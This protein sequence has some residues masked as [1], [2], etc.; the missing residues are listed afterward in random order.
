MTVRQALLVRYGAAAVV[1]TLV[2]VA[3]V[4]WVDNVRD[5]ETGAGIDDVL[6]RGLPA[7]APTNRFTDGT[8]RA[9][10][11]VRH[12][13]ATRSR[14]LPEDMGSGLAWGDCDGDGFDDLYVVNFVAPIG[15]SAEDRATR[16]GNALYRNRTDG[17]FEEIGEVAGVD[18]TAF[19]MG[20]SWGDY[21]GDGDVDLYVTNYGANVLFRNQGN[22]SFVDVTEEAGVGGGHHFSAGAVW[23]DYDGDDDLDLYVTNYVVFDEAMQARGDPMMQY[24]NIVPFTLNPASYQPAANWL[25]R[26][27]GDGRFTEVAESA[28]VANAAGRSLSAA[29]FDADADGDVDLYVAN[30]ISDNA[31]FLNRGDGSFEDISTASLTADYRGAMGL[32][33]ADYDRDADL[34]FFVTHWI[35]QENALYE[36]HMTPDTEGERPLFTDVA[37]LVGLG[38]TGLDRVGWGTS[39]IDF[40]N[41]G[42]KDLFVANGHT[43][44]DAADPTRLL[45][46]R[47]QLFWNRGEEGFFELSEVAG[48]PFGRLLVARGAAAADYDRDGDVDIA[49]LEHGGG[50]LLLVN[51]GAP[52]NHWVEIDLQQDGGNRRGIGALIR[53]DTG[54]QSQLVTV[55]G[56]SSYL[57]QDSR[58]AHFGLGEATS[59]DRVVVRWPDGTEEAFAGLAAD[60]RHTLL[61]GNG[62]EPGAVA[63]AGGA[64]SAATGGEEAAA[65]SEEAAAGSG[66]DFWAAYRAANQ[67]RRNDDRV[68]AI[69]AYERALAIRPE[70]L[71]T[72]HNLAQLRYGRGEVVEAQSLLERLADLDP[73]GN[74]AWQQLS[75]VSG[76][77]IAGWAPDLEH[78]DAMIDRALEVNPNNSESHLLKA[79]WAAYRGDLEAAEAEVEV[80]LGLSPRG[81]EAHT[82]AI[83]LAV[84]AGDDDRAERLRLRAIAAMCGSEATE[85]TAARAATEAAGPACLGDTLHAA[86]SAYWS[87][88]GRRRSGAG[89]HAAGDRAADAALLTAH[90]DLDGDGNPDLTALA[91]HPMQPA[92]LLVGGGS[93]AM[94]VAHATVAGVGWSNET[95]AAGPRPMPWRGVFLDDE[96]GR[97]L[98]LVGGGDA[99]V[100]MYEPTGAVWSERQVSG[101]PVQLA[102]AV[103]VAADWNG[104]G[105]TDLFFANVLR[106]AAP[107]RDGSGAGAK[108]ESGA[109]AGA[110]AAATVEPKTKS[111]AVGKIYWRRGADRFEPDALS[112]DGPLSAALAFDADGDGDPDLVTARALPV[113]ETAVNRLLQA[114][115]TKA[116]AEP[117]PLLTL[118][119]NDGGVLRR[120]ADAMPPIHATIQDLAVADVD[121]DVEGLLDLYVATGGLEPE[122]IEGDLLLTNHGDRFVD[123]SAA[124][125]GEARWG[126][127]LR[128]WP[129]TTGGFV[130]LRGGFGPADERLIVLSA[131]RVAGSR[132]R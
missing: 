130:L 6:A 117:P 93:A 29:W 74:R 22:C 5:V 129:R 40:D 106:S 46:Q 91:D 70:H 14:M 75:R 110:E 60:A 104:D 47:M 42:W 49:V 50:V 81:A 44:E 4:V 38:A 19:G 36:N 88:D 24:G 20:A 126:R 15:W 27:D 12:F 7:N 63:A 83:W 72:L 11:S 69:V 61:R 67:A 8:A 65:G 114:D 86:L 116:P 123:E 120:D 119:R 103:M 13:P 68:A 112:I 96:L 122:R 94:Q 77:P 3:A 82:L 1:L 131:P 108:A 66:E 109:E 25:F 53:V 118:W 127:T 33:I 16:P 34:D 32:A 107:D 52:D 43:L 54:E 55:G 39:F 111:D 79:R 101:L 125:F 121:G 80:A 9:G 84:G 10:I 100:R 23:A 97:V 51:S 56:S 128:V 62:D 92:R 115:D 124:F 73:R 98:L 2:V 35:A 102:G 28:G 76:S 21:D 113:R 64:E 31:F 30:D 90:V 71:D 41:D 58:T 105:H 132:K 26:N 17:S 89:T 78:A 37:D 87:E 59:V 85:V 18:L 45:P 48:P 99:P 57:S 95:A